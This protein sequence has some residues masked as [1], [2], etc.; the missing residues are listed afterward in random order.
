MEHV[1]AARA[2]RAHAFQRQRHPVAQRL[3][4]LHRG[5]HGRHGRHGLRVAG[6]DH[7]A[8]HA[9]VGGDLVQ[10]RTCGVGQHRGPGRFVDA[11]AQQ[12][13]AQ[14]ADLQNLE[15]RVGLGHRIEC[16]VTLTQVHEHRIEDALEIQRLDHGR[17]WQPAQI[18][19][20]ECVLHADTSMPSRS[21]GRPSGR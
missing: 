20:G 9:V 13:L 1:G 15:G 16:R 14:C 17:R 7:E 2:G 12:Q 6:T 18:D 4:R 3:V 11:G 8:R 5:R 10:V 21:T 19:L